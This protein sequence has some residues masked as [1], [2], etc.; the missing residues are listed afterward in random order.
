VAAPTRDDVDIVYDAA[1]TRFVARLDGQPSGAFLDV[2]E[3]DD[4]W[5]LIHTEVPEAL[6]G[7]GI[8]SALVRAALERARDED[9]RVNP[10]CSFVAAWLRR[11]P[12]QQDL[13]HPRFRERLQRAG[14]EA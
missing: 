7:R 12:D 10:R 5:T 4:L 6:A 2:D 8:G 11:H 14:G 9:V 13:V 1:A 3:R